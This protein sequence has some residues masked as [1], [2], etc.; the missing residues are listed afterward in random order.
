MRHSFQ[1][2]LLFT[3]C[4]G[5]MLNERPVWAAEPVCDDG[6]VSLFDGKSLAGW[7]GSHETYVIEEGLIV[8]LPHKGGNLVTEKEYS[9][10]VLRFEFLLTPGANNGI[11]LRVPSAQAHAATQGMEIQLLDDSAERY[12]NL[13]EYQFNGSIYGLIPAKRGHLKPV[14]EW[15]TK[16]IR[17]IGKQVTII[18]NGEVIVDGDIVAAVAGGALDEKEHP[19]VERTAGHLGLLGHKSTVKFRNLCIKDLSTPSQSE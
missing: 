1:L 10:F 18:L 15:N 5:L 9:D 4:F 17:C 13:K 12:K 8:S 3:C 2:L 7:T 11:G 6:F 19:G 14:G 16:E